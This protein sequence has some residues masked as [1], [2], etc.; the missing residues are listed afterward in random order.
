MEGGRGLRPPLPASGTREGEPPTGETCC[1]EPG[2][3]F[4]SAPRGATSCKAQGPGARLLAPYA[5]QALPSVHDGGRRGVGVRDLGRNIPEFRPAGRGKGPGRRGSDSAKVALRREK[6]PAAARAR[7]SP[8][9][10]LPPAGHR[11]SRQQGT[12]GL[13]P[14]PAVPNC[15]WVC[16][17]VKPFLQHPLA[18]RR[19]CRS[20]RFPPQPGEG[21]LVPLSSDSRRPPAPS[22]C[23]ALASSAA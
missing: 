23:A 15:L 9:K 1:P 8:G 11:P 16:P 12:A 5:Q 14:A 7:G 6:G 20:T 3:R 2:A 18:K 13:N 19:R 4:V 17:L 21:A 22:L 10:C